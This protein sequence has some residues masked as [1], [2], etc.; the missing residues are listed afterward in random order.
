VLGQ[1]VNVDSAVG[2]D[3]RIPV[4]PANAGVRRN[5]SFQTLSSDSSRHKLSDLPCDGLSAITA[6]FQALKKA[7]RL[8][9]Q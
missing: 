1:F 8:N 2:Q 9:L 6:D 3:A 4:Y 5:N 7:R